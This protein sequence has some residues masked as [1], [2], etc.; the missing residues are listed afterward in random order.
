EVIIKDLEI[1]ICPELIAAAKKKKQ[2]DLYLTWLFLKAID[3]HRGGSGYF[4][5]HSIQSILFQLKG[6]NTSQL[7]NLFNKGKG[8]YWSPPGK[9][10]KGNTKQR[11]CSITSLE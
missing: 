3:K 7:Y 4:S 9:N 5:T 2:L 1:V 8:I 10:I 6:V 11:F